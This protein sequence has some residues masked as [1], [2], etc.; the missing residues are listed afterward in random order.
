MVPC[1]HEC[2]ET[3]LNMF[4]HYVTEYSSPCAPSPNSHLSH[5]QNVCTPSPKAYPILALILKLKSH[6]P[7]EP[8]IPSLENS[9]RSQ[10]GGS[11]ISF[12]ACRAA[13]VQEPSF[14]LFYFCCFQ[15]KLVFFVL[16]FD[17]Q[18]KLK[19]SKSP[20]SSL[21]LLDSCFFN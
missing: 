21:F 15:S 16:Y 10:P 18:F 9:A 3:L 11:I 4:R 1:G 13:K 2:L 12:P 5:M 17:I 7:L 8:S 20:S 14:I 6:L 19:I